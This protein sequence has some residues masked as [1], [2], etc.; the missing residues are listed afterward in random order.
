MS[1]LKITK[2]Y[3]DEEENM[4]SEEVMKNKE[5]ETGSVNKEIDVLKKE[6]DEIEKLFNKLVEKLNPVL[7]I[8]E[9]TI[10]AMDDSSETKMAN[11]PLAATL[12]K[13]NKNIEINIIQRLNALISIIDI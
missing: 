13:I 7:D 2:K 9:G 6:V 10:T 1:L 11:T 12:Q 8:S 5:P 3:Y 4:K